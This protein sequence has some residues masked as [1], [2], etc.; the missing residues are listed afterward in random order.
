MSNLNIEHSLL[1][2]IKNSN[3]LLSILENENDNLSLTENNE[4][5]NY[6]LNNKNINEISIDDIN[7]KISNKVDYILDLQNNIE[8]NTEF[9]RN[10]D[11]NYKKKKHLIL[12]EKEKLKDNVKKFQ[13]LKKIYESKYINV[14]EYVLDLKKSIYRNEIINEIDNYN[15]NISKKYDYLFTNK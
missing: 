15:K 8:K 10:L 2:S 13:K 7:N 14:N 6:N 12:K 9:L 11:L 5:L 4:N 1:N 3:Q